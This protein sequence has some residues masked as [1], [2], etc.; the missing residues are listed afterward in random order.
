MAGQLMWELHRLG[1]WE[2]HHL[3]NHGLERDLRASWV[4]IMGKVVKS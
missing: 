1:D 4:K 2:E 3:S